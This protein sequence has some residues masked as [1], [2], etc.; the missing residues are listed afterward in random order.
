MKA[1]LGAF[2]KEGVCAPGQR[3]TRAHSVE[4]EA[5]ASAETGRY[6]VCSDV[7]VGRE[8]QDSGIDRKEPGTSCWCCA[9]HRR[10]KTEDLKQVQALDSNLGRCPW[11]G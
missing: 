4:G 9:T 2:L 1:A 3:S 10:W 5:L 7:S 8:Q 6:D 11:G